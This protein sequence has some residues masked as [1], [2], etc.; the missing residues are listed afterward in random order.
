MTFLNQTALLPLNRI[1]FSVT[2][3]P[4]I[5]ADT[6][7]NGWKDLILLSGNKNHFVK[8]NGKAYPSNPSVQPVFKITPGDSLPRALNFSNEPYAWFTF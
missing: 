4:L 8:F 1:H 3:Y 7:T 2:D 5:I 6:K